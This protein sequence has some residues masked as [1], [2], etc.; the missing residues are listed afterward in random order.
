VKAWPSTKRSFALLIATLLCGGASACECPPPLQGVT[1]FDRADAVFVATPTWVEGSISPGNLRRVEMRVTKILK[2]DVPTRTAVRT[3]GGPAAC[4]IIFEIGKP[5]L[6]FARADSGALAVRA[7]EGTKRMSSVTSKEMTELGGPN[8]PPRKGIGAHASACDPSKFVSSSAKPLS[9]NALDGISDL[10]LVEAILEKLGPAARDVGFGLH[11]LE[12][13]V[14][15]GRVFRVSASP[16]CG[17]PYS[18]GFGE[19]A[20]EQLLQP[21][22]ANSGRS[23]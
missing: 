9:P 16:A 14:T 13:D 10:M 22:R 5:Y 19:R 20:L 7:C 2:G 12:W 1:D 17:K 23:G 8:K 21:E 11:V 18:V 6:V 3:P 15:D 4:G